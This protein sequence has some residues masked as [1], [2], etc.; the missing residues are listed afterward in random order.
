MSFIEIE[1]KVLLNDWQRQ[2]I[3]SQSTFL[4][5]Y[6]FHDT[7]YDTFNYQLTNRDQW[8]RK[9]EDAFELKVGY[10]LNAQRIDRYREYSHLSEISHQLHLPEH[11]PF[12]QALENAQIVPFCAFKT[13]RKKYQ[14]N[15]FLIDMDLADFGCFTYQMA[16]IEMT[17]LHDSEM[18]SAER[19]LAAW[20]EKV[21]IS[22]DQAVPGKLIYYLFHQ[23][24]NHYQALAQA[25]IIPQYHKADFV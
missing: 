19:K 13:V 8:L 5:E 25:G 18:E 6:S 4:Q 14:W 12:A 16:E 21:G 9:R 24:P 15:G 1:K 20:M 10:G 22:L 17:V 11:I 3:E 7:Y 23:R 2:I